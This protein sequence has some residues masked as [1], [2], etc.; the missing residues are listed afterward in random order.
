MKVADRAKTRT[1]VRDEYARKFNEPVVVVRVE[2]AQLAAE[3]CRLHSLG[4][5]V[6]SSHAEFPYTVVI[7]ERA[8]DRS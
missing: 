7:L 1:D 4:Y 6:A 2:H 8:D 3:L 5:R